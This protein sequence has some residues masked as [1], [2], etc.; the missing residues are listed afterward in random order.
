[1]SAPEEDERARRVPSRRDGKTGPVALD[2][3]DRAIIIILQEDGRMPYSKLGPAVGLSEAAARQR[4][5][6]L[7]KDGL[8]Q[9]VAVTD[10]LVVMGS[11]MALIGLRVQGDSRW[12][13]EHLSKMPEVIYVVAISGSFDVIAELVCDDHSHLLEVLNKQ[14][15]LIEGVTATESF[16]YLG[17][18]KHTFA[19]GQG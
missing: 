16:I 12:V 17:L 6:R 3:V 9:I 15:R 4:V 1:M 18:Y 5:Q 19:Y 11:V 13:A 10:P 7:Q 8:M 2:A 14:I